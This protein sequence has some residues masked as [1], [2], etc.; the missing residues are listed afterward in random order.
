MIPLTKSDSKL[1]CIIV[2][3]YE[4]GFATHEEMLR[5]KG[6]ELGD[7]RNLR[8]DYITLDG[9]RMSFMDALNQFLD[10]DLHWTEM[11]QVAPVYL[12][13]YLLRRGF[14]A[15]F[16]S[17]FKTQRGELNEYLRSARTAAVTTTLYT[18]PIIAHQVIS[19]IREINPTIHIVM[20]GPLK[21]S[22]FLLVPCADSLPHLTGNS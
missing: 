19:Y 2:G 20:G 9:K 18:N 21:S 7:Y 8:M 10:R 15:E 6:T 12:C 1:D 5:S 13:S 11:P 4:A 14:K 22:P 16:A 3:H 17:F